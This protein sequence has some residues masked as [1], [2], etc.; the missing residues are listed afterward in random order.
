[1]MFTATGV[2]ARKFEKR[3]RTYL[4][5][6]IEV[7]ETETGELVTEYHDTV[8]LNFAPAAA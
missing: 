2:L 3:G 4:E 1:M 6:D 5:M 8:I 7:R